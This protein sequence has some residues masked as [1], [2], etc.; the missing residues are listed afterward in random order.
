MQS[1][2]QAV[3]EQRYVIAS[4]AAVTV[5]VKCN[6]AGRLATLL[7]QTDVSELAR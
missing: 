2:L 4:A 5:A 6:P 3:A 1:E 7:H